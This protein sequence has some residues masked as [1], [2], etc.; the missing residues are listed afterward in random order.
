M[1]AHNFNTSTQEIEAQ[2]SL[3]VQGHTG[4]QEL[5]LVTSPNYKNKN[6]NNKK[7]N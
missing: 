2:G 3:E 4:L 1:V 7:I 5:V 6:K